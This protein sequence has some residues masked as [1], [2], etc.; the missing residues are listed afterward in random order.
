MK[1]MIY[2]YIYHFQMLEPYITHTYMSPHSSEMSVTGVIDM[3]LEW[4][5]SN[6]TPTVSHNKNIINK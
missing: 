1:Y 4:Y 6:V 2:V 3:T 5:V